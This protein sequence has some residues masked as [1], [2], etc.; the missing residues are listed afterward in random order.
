MHPCVALCTKAFLRT[1]SRYLAIWRQGVNPNIPH[2]FAGRSHFKCSQQFTNTRAKAR[3]QGVHSADFLHW[4]FPAVT[5]SFS[6]TPH[7]SISFIG[8]VGKTPSSIGRS[9]V[10]YNGRVGPGPETHQPLKTPVD[11]QRRCQS[12]LNLCRLIPQEL[13][14]SN[15]GLSDV[16]RCSSLITIA[17][18]S[19]WERYSTPQK[20]CFL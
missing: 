6:D 12:F 3:T 2:Q 11:P 13:R 10:R 20:V 14:V 17:N 5:G 18:F 9:G 4:Y 1:S 8:W 7:D 16:C 19:T 15:R